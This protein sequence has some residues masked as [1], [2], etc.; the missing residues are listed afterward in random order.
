MK[1]RYMLPFVMMACAGLIACPGC[2]PT[3]QKTGSRGPAIDF[4]TT[5]YNFGNVRQGD[6][7]T[8][9]FRFTNT[10]TGMLVISNIHSSCGCTAALASAQEVPPGKDGEIT[11]NFSSFN[12]LGPV[13]KTVTL[14][15]NDPTR[16]S[17]VLAIEG[18]VLSDIHISSPV[19]FF[20][21]IKQ[22]DTEVRMFTVTTLT[23]SI[24]VT[25]VT[26]TNPH[27]KIKTAAQSPTQ[28]T[29]DVTVPPDAP[30]GP[31]NSVVKICFADGKTDVRYIPVI[32]DVAGP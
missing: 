7:V 24:K 11:V 23:S 13:T 22:G 10:G 15:T 1:I 2:T 32:G 16:R 29:I 6:V 12:F 31:V 26:S 25:S 30:A 9:R 14:S 5:S 18:D 27:I 28:E 8:Y 4:K 17:I 19:L 21:T 3:G 20:G